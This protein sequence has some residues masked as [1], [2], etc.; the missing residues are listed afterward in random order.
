[1]KTIFN[2]A[3][4]SVLFLISILFVVSPASQAQEKAAKPQKPAK[5]SSIN[6]YK[7]THWD[8][9]AGKIRFTVTQERQLKVI[10]QEEREQIMEARS[11][12]AD[13]IMKVLDQKQ[14]KKWD[15]LYEQADKTP[16]PYGDLKKREL[17]TPGFIQEQ[18]NPNPAQKQKINSA[19]LEYTN[20]LSKIKTN[21]GTKLEKILSKN[22]LE[23]WN[24]LMNTRLAQDKLEKRK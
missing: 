19:S 16:K 3:S 12:C 11:D 1:M 18:F 6:N 14:R 7:P 5:E 20:Q 23:N 4:L 9:I 21:T 24:D 10:L 13:K 17:L 2:K 8:A 15:S 22:Q